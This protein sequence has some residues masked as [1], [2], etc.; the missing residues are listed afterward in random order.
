MPEA[1]SSRFAIVSP[2]TTDLVSQGDD[3]LRH[4]RDRIE[5]EVAGFI[6]GTIGTR[7]AAAASN[8]G[9]IHLAT[10]TGAA[11]ISTGSAWTDIM[12]PAVF[13]AQLGLTAGGIV[14]RGKSII[15]TEESRANTA[16]GLLTTPDRV[17]GIVLPAD[18]LICVA[19]HALW[20][21]SVDLAA[22]AAIFVGANQLKQR[23]VNGPPTAQEAVLNASSGLNFYTTLTSVPIG[24]NGN[25]ST[26]ALTSDASVVTTGM[27]VAGGDTNA[28]T[29]DAA[30]GGPCYI[31][32]AAGTYDIS[33]QFKASSGS[34]T[35]KDRKLW[36]WTMGF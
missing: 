13:G 32:A 11:S 4:L 16:Y 12:V 10:D 25:V 27:S 14:R 31:F 17:S 34:V 2:S 24:L 6:V 1:P 28:A 18:G 19:Y 7:P 5:A 29:L 35:V 30:G 23:A 8:A 26:A 20:K 33:V 22:R 15:A 9:K 3:N 36:V 21:E